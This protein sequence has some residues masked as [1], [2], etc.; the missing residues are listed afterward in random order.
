MLNLAGKSKIPEK[1]IY[2]IDVVKLSQKC[3][4][5]FY[6]LT[7]ILEFIYSLSQN[8]TV[9]TLSCLV[10]FQYSTFITLF[11]STLFY[12]IVEL[13]PSAGE[14]CESG[15]HGGESRGD[16]GVRAALWGPGQGSLWQHT[17]RTG[18]LLL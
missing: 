11:Y 13:D 4:R 12:L 16:P 1:V 15:Q 2:R 6:L 3:S 9:I 5:I 17:V 10:E 18:P 8:L 7:K 14:T